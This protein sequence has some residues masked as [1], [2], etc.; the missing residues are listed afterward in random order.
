MATSLQGI[1]NMS[2]HSIANSQ[3]A[4]NVV[5]NNISN[6]NTT[7]YSKQTVA[8]NS[9]PAYN[10]YN[11]CSSTGSLQIGNGAMLVAINRNRAQWLDNYFREQYTEYGYYSQIGS[12]TN[13]IE[14]MMNNELSST[15][16]QQKL[17]DF[18]S[19]SQ[20]LTTDP[21]N[22]AYRIAFVE[23]A[24]DVA[25]MLNSMS[26]NLKYMR[27]QAV[28]TIGDPDSFDR[29]QIKM[30][31]DDLNN[32]LAQLAEINTEISKSTAGGSSNNDLLDQ[33]DV[34]L[35]EL[36]KMMPLTVTTNTNGTVNVHLGNSVLVQGG[37]Q[38]AELNAVQ[39]TD[40]NNPVAIQL[41]DMEGNVKKQDVSDR[42][43]SGSIKAILD[44]GTDGELSYKSVLD[45]ID[46]IA[47]A[48][49]QEVNNVQTGTADGTIP[50]CID[51]NGQ[52]VQATEPIFVAEGGGDFTAANIKINSAVLQDPKLVAT[53]RGDANM[54]PNAVGNT[55]NLE[56][57]NQLEN[58]KI[59]DLSNS[60]PPGEGQTLT[61]FITSLVADIGSKI[62]TINEA[63]TAQESV[64]TQAEEQRNAY[65]GVDLNQ[66]LSDLI[67]F[68]RSYEASARV[69]N[70]AADLM[71]IITQLGA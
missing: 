52:L 42:L 56:R 11:Y 38:M 70:V 62:Q 45:E 65:T 3:A 57:F 63:A 55:S 69:F 14:N 49:A 21:T 9:I 54:D 47:K 5:S 44:S 16:L 28:G 46:R 66:E 8:F 59:P 60:T 32:K 64:A 24:E 15:G 29:S 53:A 13:N 31:V 33:R 7:G 48:F 58:L 17:S 23:A 43:T 22:N 68:Q 40:D 39:T 61:G 30:S 2:Q 26:S 20:S 12:M 50:Y 25:N 71:E 51:E 4:L 37:E 41:V 18:F 1:L 36:S 19:A 34:L 35:D 67:K 6:M 10:N 27:E